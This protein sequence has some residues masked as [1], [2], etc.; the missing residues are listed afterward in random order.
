MAGFTGCTKAVENYLNGDSYFNRHGRIIND[1][2]A[3]L[4][5]LNMVAAC[6]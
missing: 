5:W 2:E 1:E 4:E 3:D 6:S